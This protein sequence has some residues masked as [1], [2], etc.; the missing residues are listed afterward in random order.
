VHKHVKRTPLNDVEVIP[1][2]AL[3]NDL[4][5]FCRNRLLLQGAQYLGGLLVIELGEGEFAGDGV[6]QA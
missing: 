4:D 2:V 3:D 5:A 6:L 1:D